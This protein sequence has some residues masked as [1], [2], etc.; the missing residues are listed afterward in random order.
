MKKSYQQPM[1]HIIRIRPTQLLCA[2][3]PVQ[4]TSNN[5]GINEE[6]TGGDG[7]ARV[8]GYNVWDDEY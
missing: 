8:K 3:G 5:A 2:S 1:L 6:V 7:P 4:R